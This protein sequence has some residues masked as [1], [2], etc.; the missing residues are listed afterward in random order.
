MYNQETVRDV[1]KDPRRED[2][3]QS[4]SETQTSGLHGTHYPPIREGK[5]EQ[6]PQITFPRQLQMAS[7]ENLREQSEREK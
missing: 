2:L 5:E 4:A 3:Q 1:W 7:N 6:R